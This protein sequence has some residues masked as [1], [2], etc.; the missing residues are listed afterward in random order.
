MA[1]RKIGAHWTEKM[2]EDIDSMFYELY[3]KYTGSGADAAEAKE[4]A[5]QAVADALYAKETAETTRD[6]L[7]RIVREQTAGGDIVPEVVQARGT[8]NTLGER[9][10]SISQDLAQ[11][12]NKTF[13]NSSVSHRNPK[14][15][16]VWID[17]D[18][19]KEVYT[20]LRPLALEYG[21]KFVSCVITSYGNGWDG[22]T[23]NPDYTHVDQML[24]MQ[25]EG[26]VEF[27]YH[28]HYHALDNKLIDMTESELRYNYENGIKI[29]KRNGLNGWRHIVYPY[30]EINDNMKRITREYFESGYVIRNQIATRPF[31]QYEIPRVS[32]DSQSA[33]RIKSD[34]DYIVDNNEMLV[35]MSHSGA[36][37]LE[38]DEVKAR[39][40]IEYAKS[41]GVPFLGVE[42]A[43][44][45]NGN[46]YQAGRNIISADGIA[47]G[48]SPYATSI[49]TYEF[50]PYYAYAPNAPLTNY[51][52]G[53]VTT[54]NVLLADA[55]SFGLPANGIVNTMRY[56]ED[57][58]YQKF[59][60]PYKS[61]R[62]SVFELIRGWNSSTGSW[63]EWQQ[64]G[65]VELMKR[66]SYPPNA[67]ATEFPP[68]RITYLKVNS[69]N[70]PDYGLP[71]AGTIEVFS[72]YEPSYSYQVYHRRL[73]NDVKRRYWNHTNGEWSAWV[74]LY[75]QSV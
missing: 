73:G 43:M 61:Y 49:G 21:I 72:D 20:K 35:L 41:K 6:E 62:N 36:T 69:A 9:L 24:Q 28:T 67:A 71:A 66:T 48:G 25:E 16:I 8:H 64:V 32:F 68:D 7:T 2:R 5:I 31:D 18:A 52:V 29:M 30:G 45:L 53:K 19:K 57:I 65:Q 59:I 3:Q 51:P 11:T 54:Q 33:E 50:V 46:L 1:Y 40:I 37:G 22:G 75:S 23:H 34:I 4:K 17:D 60:H 12:E 13:F 15:F 47:N 14:S 26:T 44:R 27:V 70:A 56:S 55:V 39:E 58:G 42:E 38:F 63:G 10:N 74:D